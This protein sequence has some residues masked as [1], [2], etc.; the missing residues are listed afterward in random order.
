ML[1]VL[2]SGNSNYNTWGIKMKLDKIR[3]AR[4]IGFIERQYSFSLSNS[5]IEHIDEL[6]DVEAP[7]TE[8]VYPHLA[9]VNNLMLHMANG[10]HKIEAI[11]SYRNLT[12]LGLK[13]SKD[14]VEKYWIAA[15]PAVEA[16]SNFPDGAKLAAKLASPETLKETFNNSTSDYTLGDILEQAKGPI[17]LRDA[18]NSSPKQQY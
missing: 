9:D 6:I 4:L 1:K 15:K 8:R 18:L 16:G 13:E 14:A 10:T 2:Y 5:E 7:V 11:K 3:F 12:G 17:K